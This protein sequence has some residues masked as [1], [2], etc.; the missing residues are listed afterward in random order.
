VVGRVTHV[1]DGQPVDP[2]DVLGVAGVERQTVGD[3]G[4]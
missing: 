1:D 3:G 4:G 2:D